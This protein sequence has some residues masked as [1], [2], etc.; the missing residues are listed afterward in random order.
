MTIER[1][2]CTCDDAGE[3]CDPCLSVLR[4][5]VDP[6][7]SLLNARWL[8]R[9]REHGIRTLADGDTSMLKAA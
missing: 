9:C 7:I 5:E 4:D 1:V 8:G 3:M 6:P 2:A